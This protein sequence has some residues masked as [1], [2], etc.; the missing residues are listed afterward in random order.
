MLFFVDSV[1]VVVDFLGFLTLGWGS[2]EGEREGDGL[3]RGFDGWSS[4]ES[5]RE[6]ERAGEGDR[7]GVGE[8]E[9]ERRV[10]DFDVKGFFSKYSFSSNDSSSEDAPNRASYLESV[11]SSIDSFPSF[12]SS[13][14]SSSSSSSPGESKPSHE[15]SSFFFFDN[16]CIVFSI[17]TSLSSPSSCAVFFEFFLNPPSLSP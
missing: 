2:G 15:S 12:S 17:S 10:F 6:M 14:E 9:R 7:D 13:S 5:E 11:S 8:R 1:G 16:F 4:S 3:R